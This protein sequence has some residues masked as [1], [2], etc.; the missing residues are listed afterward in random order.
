M[1]SI[2][3]FGHN[4]TI[5]PAARHAV[6][7]EAEVLTIL[8]AYRG[9]RIKAIGSLHAW[10]P[11]ADTD[12]VLIEMSGLNSVEV[13]EDGTS[14]WIGAGCRVKRAL[15]K[16]ARRRLTL[17]SVGLIDKQ[18]VAGATATATHGSGKSSLSHFIKSVRIAHY[19]SA[20]GQAIISTIDDGD[21]LKAA[22]CSL[23]LLGIVVAIEFHCRPAYNVQEHARALDSLESVLAMEADFP[24]QQFYRMPWSWNYFG[25]HRLETSK[26]RS[27][28]ASLYRT[29]CFCVIDVGLH[30]AVTTLSRFLKRNWATRFFFKRV[31]RWTIIPHWK[32]VDDSHA[33][34]VMQHDLF[35]HV[36]IEVFVPR[37]KLHAATDLLTDVVSVCGGQ[38][39]RSAATTDRLLD[40]ID[41]TA[42][43]DSLHGTYC[44]HYPICYRR[45]LAD[46]TLVS[47]T[48]PSEFADAKE[49]WY[50]ISFI[51]YQRRGERVGFYNFADFIGP[52]VAEL[53]GG[54]CHWGKY[55][56]LICEQN[57]GLYPQLASFCEIVKQ[58]DPESR[59]AN[60]WLNFV[61]D[62]PA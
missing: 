40:S 18:T 47:M 10:S 49:D 3:N 41:R 16:L 39:K 14:V 52:V 7:T 2:R 25:H 37:S 6:E 24:L 36:E 4:V 45:V 53:F 28:L 51:S 22:R 35:R 31:L 55:N 12:G 9:Q 38:P 21:A 23:G 13:S 1:A 46:D 60:D 62:E 26:N 50:A 59:F 17:P 48:G 20:T 42:E 58:F 33:M 19:D 57:K 5:E 32:V 61:I 34:L 56:P 15:R 8:D 43:L 30:L 54:R 44:H 27:K 11:I 29:Y